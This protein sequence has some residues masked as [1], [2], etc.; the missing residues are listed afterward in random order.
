MFRAHWLGW[1]MLAV[2]LCLGAVVSLRGFRQRRVGPLLASLLFAGI[3]PGWWMSAYS[4]DCGTSRVSG[5][6]LIT[7]LFFLVAIVG[8]WINPVERAGAGVR[9]VLGCAVA[10]AIFVLLPM[11][12]FAV[13]DSEWNACLERD[14]S[15][16]DI[17]RR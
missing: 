15:R 7:G 17:R 5:S 2:G 16:H 12:S 1:L 8:R 10:L 6:A 4:G 9:A 13:R 3:N 14:D 11:L